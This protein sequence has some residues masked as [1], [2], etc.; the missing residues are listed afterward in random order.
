MDF[1]LK[2]PPSQWNPVFLKVSS[3]KRFYGNFHRNQPSVLFNH[4]QPK[5]G[6]QITA[7]FD[8]VLHITN[9]LKTLYEKSNIVV[10][11]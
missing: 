4:R 8:T 6:A 11:T 7:S 2:K 10:K 1:E 5:L 9:D 3:S